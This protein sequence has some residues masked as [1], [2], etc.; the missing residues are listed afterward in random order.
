MT[1]PSIQYE[2]E[3]KESP[4]IRYD[5]HK[6]PS[7]PKKSENVTKISIGL[8]Q[9][10]RRPLLPKSAIRKHIHPTCY[11]PANAEQFSVERNKF[12]PTELNTVFSVQP[13]DFHY[14]KEVTSDIAH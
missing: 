2:D 3:R 8:H 11:S 12:D 14:E 10:V 6:I 13:T 5:G 4:A 9:E 1:K 7:M